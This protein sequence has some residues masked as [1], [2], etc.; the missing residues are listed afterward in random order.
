MDLIW[1]EWLLHDGTL[2]RKKRDFAERVTSLS[3]SQLTF[4]GLTTKT[5]ML[6]FP[7]S[8]RHIHYDSAFRAR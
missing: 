7:N 3:L 4:E 2:L 6:L 8:T 1:R 5:M